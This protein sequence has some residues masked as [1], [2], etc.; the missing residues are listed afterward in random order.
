MDLY[1]FNRATVTVFLVICSSC[2]F[3]S[4]SSSSSSSSVSGNPDWAKVSAPPPPPAAIGGDGGWIIKKEGSEQRKLTRKGSISGAEGTNPPTSMTCAKIFYDAE[5]G[6]VYDLLS[7]SHNEGDASP[8]PL[9]SSHPLLIN[10]TGL[11]SNN[12]TDITRRAASVKKSTSLVDSHYRLDVQ[13][14]IARGLMIKNSSMP[15]VGISDATFEI[16]RLEGII[17]GWSYN[18]TFAFQTGTSG[19]G[20]S[21]SGGNF[22]FIGQGHF[23]LF[24][25]N[26]NLSSDFVSATLEGN[27]SKEVD[28]A[29]GGDALCDITATRLVVDIICSDTERNEA[30]VAKEC[31]DDGEGNGNLSSYIKWKTPRACAKQFALTPSYQNSTD[32]FKDL[33]ESKELGSLELNKLRKKSGNWVV[34]DVH[35]PV[36][37]A[38]YSF[39]INPC[40]SLNG[41]DFM[42]PLSA[43]VGCADASVCAIGKEFNEPVVPFGHAD[44]IR[45]Y[46]ETGFEER[47][48]SLDSILLKK[49]AQYVT[50]KLLSPSKSKTSQNI[51][52]STKINFV[53]AERT[54]PPNFIQSICGGDSSGSILQCDYV[55]DWQTPY[56]CVSAFDVSISGKI[57]S[58]GKRNARVDIC[59]WILLFVF[60]ICLYMA[61]VTEYRRR[62]LGYRG[63]KSLP[64][65][66]YFRKA[67]D[68][69]QSFGHFAFYVL[70]P[71]IGIAPRKGRRIVVF[72][73]NNFPDYGNGHTLYH[74]SYQR[75]GLNNSLSFSNANDDTE[76]TL[77]FEDVDGSVSCFSTPTSSPIKRKR[78]G[79]DAHIGIVHRP[80]P[81]VLTS[82]PQARDRSGPNC[83]STDN[84]R[85]GEANPPSPLAPSTPNLLD[86]SSCAIPS[87]NTRKTN[88]CPS[89]SG[90]V[91][92]G[93]DQP[94]FAVEDET[95]QSSDG[96][97][98][99]TP[100]GSPEQT[101]ILLFERQPK[102]P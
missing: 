71:K 95:A 56:G 83:Y 22:S 57:E 36:E 89:S 8:G 80:I 30:N 52:R 17:N 41:L 94:R 98:Y 37:N 101:R 2:L 27:S 43:S 92:S 38:T 67:W 6:G 85:F 35:S 58:T 48:S 50:V 84:F 63:L 73:A 100:R 13:L 5:T 31:G 87:S 70:L 76:S 51:T 11:D 74:T 10:L 9:F 14:C 12:Q 62:Y 102:N 49:G 69:I 91:R 82:T 55:F 65:H 33:C 3:H 86:E 68:R 81:T 79:I 4:S 29:A 77:P 23:R 44:S 19:D 60:V 64:H 40:G 24:L 66:L 34:K 90:R 78:E 75:V 26:R 39:V 42:S 54:L 59:F 93:L 96:S 46:T 7:S 99:G 16:E 53:C 72:E 97:V 25:E 15:L 28:G 1:L 32:T 20:L 47:N 18:Q 45:L 61:L 21:F 88:L